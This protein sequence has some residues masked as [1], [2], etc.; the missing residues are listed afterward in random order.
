M[1]LISPYD[2][3]D[4]DRE[5]DQ[6]VAHLSRALGH[7]NR[8]AG[9]SAYLA[10][11]THSGRSRRFDAAAAHLAPA[12]A[13]ALHHFVAKSNWDDQAIQAAVLEWVFPHIDLECDRY[14]VID[15]IAIPKKGQHSVGVAYQPTGTQSKFG[16][17]QVAITLSLAC[18]QTSVALA[19][20]LYLPREWV[21]HPSRRKRVGVPEPLGYRAKSDIAL[22]LMRQ[23]S[24]ARRPTG[25]VLADA[26]F[27]DFPEVRKGVTA[28]GMRYAMG[29]APTTRVRLPTAAPSG[30]LPDVAF[31]VSS[32]AAAAS[33]K[34]GGAYVTV[35]T[36]AKSLPQRL[37][38]SISKSEAAEGTQNSRFARV[39]VRP[40]DSDQ[41]SLA[42][43]E[44]ACLLIEQSENKSIPNSYCL[45]T[46]DASLSLAEMVSACKM[47]CETRL[48]HDA[49]KKSFDLSHF[50]GRGW[51]G[52]HH[53]ATLC[54]AAYGFDLV[55]RLKQPQQCA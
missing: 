41:E 34:S 6:F 53:H 39:R 42:T 25:M 48:A 28:L 30:P 55:Q 13:Q 37:W 36:L 3:A 18:H 29:I 17:C 54:M 49:M 44:D 46:A 16:Q 38:Q 23:A 7:I 2:L 47:G 52:F 21:D 20:Q 32:T 22:A 40:L 1:A 26:R 31:G 15:E 8:H 12:N 19:H 35:Q 14:W 4:C 11:L 10:G 51:R 50:E 5:F 24:A 43:D 27:G 9:L 33:F 45:T